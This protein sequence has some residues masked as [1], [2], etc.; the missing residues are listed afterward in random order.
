MDRCSSSGRC[1]TP[2]QYCF[3]DWL[4]CCR[5][6]VLLGF[7]LLLW[8]IFSLCSSDN[9]RHCLLYCV[10]THSGASLPA[11]IINIISIAKKTREVE[12]LF[13][14]P[15]ED[16]GCRTMGTCRIYYYAL[17]F[18]TDVHTT[19]VVFQINM[20]NTGGGFFSW[21][22]EEKLLDQKKYL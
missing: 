6:A 19:V 2:C 22:K 16:V 11:P 4:M 21:G 8:L 13:L 12:I 9:S 14:R 17:C 10:I 15:A 18:L 5:C 3:I 1:G 7:P 20:P